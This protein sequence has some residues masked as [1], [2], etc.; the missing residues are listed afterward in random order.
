VLIIFPMPIRV[1]GLIVAAI[2]VIQVLTGNVSNAG[3]QVC[4]LAGAATAMVI[5]SAWGI[6][7]GVRIGPGRGLRIP[8]LGR[9]RSRR[10][11]GAWERRQ[12]RLAQEQT[13]V[14]RILAKVHDHGLNSLTWTERRTLSRAT[15]RQKKREDELDRV[16]RL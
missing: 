14:D 1:F 6:M 13:E 10:A 5:F 4:H 16:D 2:A 3:G 9:R 8:F 15:Q 7:P 12:R 11:E